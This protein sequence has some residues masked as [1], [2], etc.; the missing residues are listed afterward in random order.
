MH[1]LTSAQ[2]RGMVQAYMVWVQ[3]PA[4]LAKQADKVAAVSPST[5]RP[6]RMADCPR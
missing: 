3:L 1:T 6:A 5:E 4:V 2:S